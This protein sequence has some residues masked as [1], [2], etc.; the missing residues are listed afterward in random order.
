LVAARRVLLLME[1]PRARMLG[2]VAISWLLR[3]EKAKG[4]R[5]GLALLQNYEKI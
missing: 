1:Y 3:R 4:K 2:M 5:Q